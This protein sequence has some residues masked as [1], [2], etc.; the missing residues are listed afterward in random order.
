[1]TFRCITIHSLLLY[2]LPYPLYC[3]ACPCVPFRLSM[4]ALILFANLLCQVRTSSTALLIASE[5][6]ESFRKSK[7]WAFRKFICNFL[8][9]SSLTL[10]S[11]LINS[12]SSHEAYMA[13]LKGKVSFNCMYVW[14]IKNFIRQRR[15]FAIL[16]TRH[17]CM[18]VSRADAD[19]CL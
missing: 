7:I 8:V 12:I 3:C 2:A 15:F 11:M 10:L 17:H 1:M 9:L 5:L 13:R 4:A 16:K 18:C 14:K 19:V 6:P